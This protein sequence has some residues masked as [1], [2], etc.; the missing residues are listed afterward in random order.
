[1]ATLFFLGLP[2]AYLMERVLAGRAAGIL[3]MILLVVTPMYF[4]RPM[5]WKKKELAILSI[6]HGWIGT[7][8]V[9]HR[10]GRRGMTFAVLCAVTLSMGIFIKLLDVTAVVPILLLV[11]H[12]SGTFGTRQVRAFG[13]VYCR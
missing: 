11:S 1:M 2:G 7:H 4:G 6:S 3:A 9:E 10:T 13:A 5:Y 12:A 8:V